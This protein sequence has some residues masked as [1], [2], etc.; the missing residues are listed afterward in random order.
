MN[1]SFKKNQQY[2]DTRQNRSKLILEILTNLNNI[3]HLN[4]SP[5]QKLQHTLSL[6]NYKITRVDF[7]N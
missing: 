5:Y 6:I 7:P 4:L 2:I 1:I 3:I